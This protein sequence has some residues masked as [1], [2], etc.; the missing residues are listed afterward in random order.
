MF[1]RSKVSQQITKTL[2]TLQIDEDRIRL[3]VQLM[4]YKVVKV[5]LFN[6]LHSAF[7]KARPFEE[8]I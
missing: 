6:C 8:K 2:I 7:Q 1:T 4:K 3:Q 5:E